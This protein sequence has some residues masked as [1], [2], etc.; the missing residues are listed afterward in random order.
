MDRLV[1]SKVLS[2]EETSC[3]GKYRMILTHIFL[4]C[5][6]PHHEDR[7]IKANDTIED[8]VLWYFVQKP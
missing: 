8:K 3:E 7:R 5:H 6:V 1:V 4:Y 2:V